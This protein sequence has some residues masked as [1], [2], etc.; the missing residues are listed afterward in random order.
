ML[1]VYELEIIMEYIFF[2]LNIN[3]IPQAYRCYV[4]KTAP[5]EEKARFLLEECSKKTRVPAENL[6]LLN[7]ING[8]P[9]EI[10]LLQPNISKICIYQLRSIKNDTR[11]QNI[12]VVNIFSKPDIVVH[13]PFVFRSDEETV[14]VLYAFVSGKVDIFK[15]RL[16]T[17]YFKAEK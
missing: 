13:P 1:P 3:K 14:C 17:K 5:A 4:R 10:S 8:K 2:P 16:I 9:S 7:L 12:C 15:G 6:A 11:K